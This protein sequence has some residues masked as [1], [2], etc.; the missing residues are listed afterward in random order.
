MSSNCKKHWLRSGRIEPGATCWPRAPG[1][2]LCYLPVAAIVHGRCSLYIIC[3]SISRCVV[4]CCF[5]LAPQPLGIGRE[6]VLLTGPPPP[7]VVG[8]ARPANVMLLQWPVQCSAV[9]CTIGLA[10]GRSGCTADLTHPASRDTQVCIT[11]TPPHRPTATLSPW[12][13][14]LLPLA[15]ASPWRASAATWAATYCAAWW[16]NF[17]SIP[18]YYWLAPRH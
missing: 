15:A 8:A 5:L 1:R 12:L 4:T 2:E 14:P 10:T 13:L 6:P 7:A 3:R 11:S 16:S 9:R 18:T 17:L